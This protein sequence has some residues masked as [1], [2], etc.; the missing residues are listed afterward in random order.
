MNDTSLTPQNGDSPFDGIRRTRPD[1]SD[2]WSARDLMPLLGY[3]KW[4]RFADAIS[5][6]ITA[7]TVQGADAGREAS[8][9]RE[10][11]ATSGNAPDTERENFHLTR[12]AA[13]QVAMCGDPRKPE[14]AAALAY[15]AIRTREAETA[16]PA[17]QIPQTMSEA[18]RLA[19]NEYDRAESEKAARI[20]TERANRELAPAASAW[21]HLAQAI[22]DYSVG[23]AAKILSRAPRITIGRDRLFAFMA[24]QSW[25]YRSTGGRRKPWR[26][27]QA[28]VDL[29]RLTERI[30]PM[31]TDPDTG[32]DRLPE[33]TVRITVKGLAALHK[34]LGGDGPAA[35]MAVVK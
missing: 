8:R 20:E 27:Y 25:V 5:R 11:V 34:L 19:A 30:G 21:D 23:D 7:L 12:F 15:F 3:E 14:V 26:A 6:A 4:E 31:Y 2:F 29:G 32:E 16:K 9:L 18:L 13:Y 35:S 33:P 22:G 24:A 28:Q 10:S 17:F 1:G